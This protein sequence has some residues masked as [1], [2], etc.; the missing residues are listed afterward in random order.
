MRQVAGRL[1]LDLAQYRE[2]EAFAQFGSELD[3]A[4]QQTL[5]RGERMVAT[6]NQ[7]QYSPWAMEEQVVAIFAGI[8][9]YLDPIPT[10]DVPRFQDE[11][12]EHMRAEKAIYAEIR[13]EKELTDELTARLHAEIKR[14]ANTFN[15]EAGAPLS[16]AQ[17][18]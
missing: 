13:E 7:P 5:A 4:T 9:G 8:N 17:P 2:L 16:T 12:R 11:L 14:F 3:P 6:L 10:S 18:G 1:K 15:V